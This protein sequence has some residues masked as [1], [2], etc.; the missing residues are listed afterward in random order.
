M[1]IFFPLD[2]AQSLASFVQ[3]WIDIIPLHHEH[4]INEF[5]SRL[6]EQEGADFP[7]DDDDEN[8]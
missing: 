6:H 7:F 5:L 2:S 4:D 1:D 8:G 3:H